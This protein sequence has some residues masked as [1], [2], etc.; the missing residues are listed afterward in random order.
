MK[1]LTRDGN[2]E[3][4]GGKRMGRRLRKR[5]KKEG[6]TERG[7]AAVGAAAGGAALLTSQSPNE[8]Y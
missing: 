6:L 4:T 1:P 8:R 3:T 2:K 5:M 7:A